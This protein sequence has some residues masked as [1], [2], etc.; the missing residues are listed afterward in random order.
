[1]NAHSAHLQEDGGPGHAG[2]PHSGGDSEHGTHGH[3]AHMVADF[4]RRFWVS[5]ALTVPI[6]AISPGLWGLLGLE[7]P[8]AFPGDRYA[9]F[10]LASAVYFYGGRAGLSGL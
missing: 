4:R 8:L 3:H 6:L 9:L 5:L 2:Q 10:T 1:M 7:A